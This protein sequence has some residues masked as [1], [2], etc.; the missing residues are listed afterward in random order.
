MRISRSWVR[1]PLRAPFAAAT[2]P[3]NRAANDAVAGAAK[4]AHAIAG[5]AGVASVA[6]V[7][8]VAEIAG[9]TEIAGSPRA[10]VEVEFMSNF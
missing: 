3:G 7:A 6:G 8:G 5:V 10:E 4:A 9:V 2:V 1:V